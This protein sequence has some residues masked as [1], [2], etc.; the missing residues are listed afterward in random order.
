M[1]WQVRSFVRCVFHRMCRC[2]GAKFK[3]RA[4]TCQSVGV[5]LKHCNVIWHLL[6]YW[7]AF[8]CGRVFIQSTM[9]NI[10]GQMQNCGCCSHR[11]CG[12]WRF[13]FHWVVC[14][15]VRGDRS[16]VLCGGRGAGRGNHHIFVVSSCRVAT[17]HACFIPEV[18]HASVMCGKFL[19][20]ERARSKL[21]LG[22]CMCFAQTGWPLQWQLWSMH[23]SAVFG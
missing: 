20:Q 15:P 3:G 1:W 5:C 4:R 6:M 8:L 10:Y 9:S 17:P 23:A 16:N 12:L 13:A 21:A 22:S 18:V 2:I 7:C 14:S 19:V 11:D